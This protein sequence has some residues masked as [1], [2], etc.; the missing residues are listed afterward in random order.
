M[1]ISDCGIANPASEIR[2]PKSSSPSK[3]S[4]NHTFTS[5]S[6]MNKTLFF[7]LFCGLL[8]LANVAEAQKFGYTNS[9]ALLAE[10]PEIKQADADLEAF[11]A[12]LQK[13][14]QAMVTDLQAKGADLEKRYKELGTISAKQYQDEGALLQ[15]EEAKIQ[16][17]EQDMYQQLSKKK[18]E[19]YKPIL[20]RVNAA[21]KTVA[22]EGGFMLIYDASS[23]IL[24]YADEANDVTK[25]V[26]AKLGL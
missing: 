12:Q 17:Y 3:F 8:L 11:Q 14:G 9:V 7:G 5:F 26:K 18:E 15:A 21:I 16:T 25:T 22:V 24:L 6:K 13:K 10:M 2:N 1:R 19:S 23:G 4:P 20:D